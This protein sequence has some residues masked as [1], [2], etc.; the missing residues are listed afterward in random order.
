MPIRTIVFDFGNVL[1]RFCHRRA[2]E[3]VARL[4][5]PSLSADL[6]HAH[7]LDADLEERFEKAQL[8]AAEVLASMRAKFGLAGT[9]AELAFACSDIFTPIPETHAVIRRLHGRYRLYLLSNTNELHFARFRQQF[10]EV[11]SLFDGILASHLVGLRKP[12][13]AIYRLIEQRSGCR[14]EE[15]LFIDDLPANVAAAEA[16]GWRAIRFIEG[17]DL[18]AELARHGVTLSPLART[19]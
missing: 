4:G 13:P 5:P 6:V 16:L 17:V 3:Q 12:D 8:T 11:L 7:I 1:A 15:C 19:A 18:A 10:D 2:A 9:D 14:P